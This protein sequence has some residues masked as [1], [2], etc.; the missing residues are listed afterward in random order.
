ME[1]IFITKLYSSGVLRYAETNSD[2]D[3]NNKWKITKKGPNSLGN[4]NAR[5]IPIRQRSLH[6]SML[7]YLDVS[8]SSAS[9][10]GQTT[11]LS[12]Y[13]D[14]KSLYFDDSLYENEMHYK[15]SKYLDENP[16]G[17]DYEELRIVCDSEKE[18]N[19]ALDTL[20]KF[21]DGKLRMFG[22]SNNPMEIVVE[23]DPRDGYRKFDENQLMSDTEED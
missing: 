5:R 21:Y 7:G 20:Y 11:S 8:D 6:P 22:V 17:D 19:A 2:M 1:D 16:L 14:M 15:I 12:P 4:Q 18:Y 3:M 10:P 9:D 23:K 13:C